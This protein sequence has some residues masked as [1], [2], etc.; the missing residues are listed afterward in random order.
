MSSEKNIQIK[1]KIEPTEEQKLQ[2]RW[3]YGH[4]LGVETN[5]QA[6]NIQLAHRQENNY[7]NKVPGDAILHWGGSSNDIHYANHIILRDLLTKTDMIVANQFKLQKEIRAVRNLV[8]NIKYEDFEITQDG[9][10]DDIEL[11]NSNKGRN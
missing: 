9:K 5:K 3:S 1:A 8:I 2:Y 7:N 4:S 10:F 11:R 6:E